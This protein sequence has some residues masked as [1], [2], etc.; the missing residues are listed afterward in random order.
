MPMLLEDLA[1]ETTASNRRAAD[2][3]DAEARNL[4][5]LRRAVTAPEDLRQRAIASARQA[6]DY[7]VSRVGSAEGVWRSGLETLRQ[8]P[9][10]DDAERLLR[11]LLGVFESGRRLA[12]LARALWEIAGQ[13]GAAPEPLDELDR[14]EERFVD[15]AAEVRR[16]LDHRGRDWQPADPERFAQGLRLAREGKAATADE[17]RAWF[18]KAGG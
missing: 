13:S 3:L 18:R 7:T 4:E 6:T 12:R 9:T 16:A 17:A 10:G 2:R 14:A 11:T 15:L 8:R 5:E 1:E